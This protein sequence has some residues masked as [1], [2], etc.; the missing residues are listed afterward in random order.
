MQ[1]S[2]IKS[3][4]NLSRLASTLRD[5]LDFLVITTESN[6]MMP[7]HIMDQV[8]TFTRHKLKPMKHLE[9]PREVSF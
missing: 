3:S 7:L 2:I 8:Q 5:V 9:S 6:A 4:F 1:W